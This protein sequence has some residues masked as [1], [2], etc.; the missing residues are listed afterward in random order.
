VRPASATPPE[1]SPTFSAGHLIR[2]AHRAMQRHLEETITQQGVSRG[3]W[4][5]LRVL[6]EGDGLTQRELSA[7]VGMMEPT[8]VVALNGMEKTGLIRRERNPED[9][10]KIH[11]FL[12]DKG[13]ALRDT[14]LPLAQK[15]NDRAC[16][17]IDAADLAGFRRAI[18]MMIRNLDAASE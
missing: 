10:R 7:R 2:D 4:Y 3:Q 13:T 17:G 18:N 1:M 14:L 12:T 9:R 8:T 11:I 16:V 15:I 6:W 5:F